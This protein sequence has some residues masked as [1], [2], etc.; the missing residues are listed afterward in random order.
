[1]QTSPY[2]RNPTM[3]KHT[4]PK[5]YNSIR[6]LNISTHARHHPVGHFGGRT[7]G[8]GGSPRPYEPQIYSL[9]I[10]VDKTKVIASDGIACRILIQNE[11]LEQVDTF[12]Y[13]DL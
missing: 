9:L 6:R 8:V 12:P 4:Q 2:V 7:T 3:P 5:L 10:N 13:P 1:M 11:Q